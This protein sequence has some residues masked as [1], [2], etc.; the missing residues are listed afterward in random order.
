LAQRKG[1]IA[2]VV[3]PVPAMSYVVLHTYVDQVR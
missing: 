1:A 3:V 2:T